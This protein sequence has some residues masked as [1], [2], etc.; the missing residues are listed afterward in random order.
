MANSDDVPC[1]YCEERKPK[2]DEHVVQ[3]GLGGGVT[4]KDLVCGDCNTKVF[5]GPDGKLIRYIRE[6]AC[7]SHPDVASKRSALAWHPGLYFDDELDAWVSVK[8]G[9]FSPFDQ[10][11]LPE[12]RG[13]GPFD[14]KIVLDPG[15]PGDPLDRVARMMGELGHPESLSLKSWVADGHTPPVQP[16]VI[17]SGRNSYMLRG[18]SE[19]AVEAIRAEVEAG[20][21]RTFTNN[22]QPKRGKTENPTLNSNFNMPLGAIAQ[23]L[24]KMAMNFLALAWGVDVARQPRF[25][26]VK[27]AVR[28]GAG[29]LKYVRLFDGEDTDRFGAIPGHHCIILVGAHAHG[30]EMVGARVWLF[31]KLIATINLAEAVETTDVL[32]AGLFDYKTRQHRIV[33]MEELAGE[34]LTAGVL[35]SGS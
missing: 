23:A 32:R 8:M 16:A 35:P 17:R 10:L 1:L 29:V 19:P 5:S 22:D 7:R 27:T 33:T 11:I 6:L 34:L 3:E 15:I 24:A 26:P 25:D 18:A 30:R 4:L 14:T 9:D 20:R 13:T 2:T 12:E 28:T 31:Q 21:F